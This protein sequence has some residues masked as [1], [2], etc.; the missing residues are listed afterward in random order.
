MAAPMDLMALLHSALA[1]ELLTR[2]QSGEATAADLGVVAKFL[3][4]NGIEA[5]GKKNPDINALARQ[6]PFGE[7]DLEDLRPN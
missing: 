7:D 1:K 6:F 4:D 2:V 5:D 3:K